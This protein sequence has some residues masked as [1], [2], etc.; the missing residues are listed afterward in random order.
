MWEVLAANWKLYPKIK[1]NM[2][3]YLQMFN[4]QSFLQTLINA[5]QIDDMKLIEVEKKYNFHSILH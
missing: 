5:N 2:T 3:L 4:I 1:I